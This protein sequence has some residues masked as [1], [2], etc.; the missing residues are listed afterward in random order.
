MLHEIDGVSKKLFAEDCNHGIISP[1][2][3][4]HC[5]ECKVDCDDKAE[6]K[7]QY[8]AYEDYD[9]K[10]HNNVDYSD[11]IGDENDERLFH[12]SAEKVMQQ[13]YET[14]DYKKIH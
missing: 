2:N 8:K 11:H 13:V 5:A 3:K 10:N 6:N 14:V 9:C 4:I 1:R 12:H 7:I